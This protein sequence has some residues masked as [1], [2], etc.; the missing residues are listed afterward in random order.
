MIS[1]LFRRAPGPWW[2][3]T[4]IGLALVA[5]IFYFLFEYV[6]PPIHEY[7]DADMTVIQ[8]G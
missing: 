3:K 5:V 2:L 4:I 6:Y 7:F 1:L 8:G